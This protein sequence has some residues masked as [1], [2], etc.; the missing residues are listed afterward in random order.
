MSPALERIMAARVLAQNRWP[1]ISHLLF[2]LRLVPVDPSVLESMGVD[3]GWR[4]YFNEEFVMR[5]TVDNLATVLQ[6]EAMHCML[7]HSERFPQLRDSEPQHELFNIA[8]DC[9]IN[10]V[11]EESGFKFEGKDQPVRYKDFPEINSRMSTEQAYYILKNRKSEDPQPPKQGKGG[12]GDNGNTA[13]KD[14][15]SVS[16]GTP[17]DYEISL[18]DDVSPAASEETK[19]VVK[20]QVAGAIVNAGRDAGSIPGEL[21]RWADDFQNP[22]INWRRQLAVRVRAALA[23]KAGRRD[24]SMMRPSRREQGL[25]SGE[26]RFRLPA[27]RQPND[28][29]TKV[30]VDTSGSITQEALK[31]TLSEVMGITKAVGNSEG[32]F[33]I[34]CDSVAYPAQ[35]V[36]SQADVKK[37]KLPGGGGTDMGEGIYA[38]ITAKPKPDVVVVVTDGYTPWPSRK[39]IGC[40]N[41]IVLLTESAQADNVPSWAKT[42]IADDLDD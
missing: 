24:Y 26:V 27:M 22:K 8:A 33:V 18:D 21:V 6:H 38:A 11:I 34:P 35:R 1:Y 23:T 20:A 3:A 39:P 2:S 41:Y 7:N 10:H 32:I 17:R 5:Q 16:G 42:I 37:M 29:K 30:V 13:S 40:D 19:S 14:C 36:K 9:G 12:K 4:L 31:I 28:P 15:G 25:V